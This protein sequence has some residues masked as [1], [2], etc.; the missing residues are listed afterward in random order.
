MNVN[1]Y[2]ESVQEADV[3]VMLDNRHLVI[4]GEQT[5]KILRVRSY[6]MQAFRD[7]YFERG[8]Y[9]VRSV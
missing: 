2:N 3:D 5:S 1:F 6:L 4:R 8:Y 9:E 7:H